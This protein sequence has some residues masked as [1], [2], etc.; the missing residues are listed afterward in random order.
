MPVDSD[1]NAV[2]VSAGVHPGLFTGLADAR[3]RNIYK[4]EHTTPPLAA[5]GPGRYFCAVHT[6][7]GCNSQT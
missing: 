1:G 2:L 5:I 4:N 7:L 6:A 3:K